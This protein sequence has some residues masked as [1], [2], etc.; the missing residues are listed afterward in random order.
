MT[1]YNNAFNSG[2]LP[3]C[4]TCEKYK[5]GCKRGGHLHY[6]EE[7]D[8]YSL[9]KNGVSWTIRKLYKDFGFK[10]PRKYNYITEKTIKTTNKD[11][12][13]HA[14]S[15]LGTMQEFTDKLEKILKNKK[16]QEILEENE[17]KE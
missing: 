13:L 9:S 5:N 12:L 11:V 6:N 17:L 4:D 3:F 1:N 7:C 10:I 2:I 14:Q 15:L 16:S 8:D